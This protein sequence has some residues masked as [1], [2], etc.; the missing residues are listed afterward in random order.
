MQ[1]PRCWVKRKVKVLMWYEKDKNDK[2]T[3]T[4]PVCSYTLMEVD[5]E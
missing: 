3:F 1:C 4:C 5:H 2:D